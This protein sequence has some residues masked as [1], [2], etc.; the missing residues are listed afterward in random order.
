MPIWEKAERAPRDGRGRVIFCHSPI[1][2]PQWMDGLGD[3]GVGLAMDSF[4]NGLMSLMMGGWIW[5]G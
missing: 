3:G 4:G 5:D 1:A 2:R